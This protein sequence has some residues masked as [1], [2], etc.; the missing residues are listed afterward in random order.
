LRFVEAISRHL[1][2]GEVAT[3]ATPKKGKC[4]RSVEAKRTNWTPKKEREEY[5]IIQLPEAR[6]WENWTP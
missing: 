1:K 5:E 4:R 2:S 3:I 6:N